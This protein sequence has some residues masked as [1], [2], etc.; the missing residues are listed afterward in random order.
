MQDTKHSLSVRSILWLVA[1]CGAGLL[2]YW[3]YRLVVENV[4]PT[5]PN[6]NGGDFWTFLNAARIITRGQTLYNPAKILGG[7]G[8]VYSPVIAFILV[9]FA[10]AAILK[11]WL[12]YTAVEIIS[13]VIFASVATL[14][15]A[16]YLRSW[17]QPVFFGFTIFTVILFVPTESE[18]YNGQTDAFALVLLAVASLM[19]QYD[20]N[21]ASGVLIGLSGLIKTWPALTVVAIFRRGHRGRIRTLI[22]CATALLVGP[23]LSFII[24]GPSGVVNFIKVTLDA[25]SQP[26][27][28]Y[29]VWGVPNILFSRS[30][31][32]RPVFVSAP[33]RDLAVLSLA[34][35]VIA[36]LLLGLRWSKNPSLSFWN[37][38]GC[39]ILL[40]PVSHGYYTLYL[41]PIFWIWAARWITEPRLGGLVSAV[42]CLLTLWWLVLFHEH[43][44]SGNA[45]V[46]AFHYSVLFFANLAAVTASIIGDHLLGNSAAPKSSGEALG[47]IDD[48][49]A[50]RR[51]VPRHA[52]QPVRRSIYSGGRE[53]LPRRASRQASDLGR[54]L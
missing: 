14:A 29:S 47:D 52:V 9:P 41:L 37:V 12:M 11:L 49:A 4:T 54:G 35:L 10:G 48:S 26:L 36:L 13:F 50:F 27:I 6:G 23:L 15:A 8:Y 18:L 7:T 3:R 53:Y 34:M 46:S 22:G 39:A 51:P 5:G 21:A 38:A 33:L 25:R 19:S 42:T 32:A 30:G 40:L 45:G 1:I 31:L 16:R 17:Q 43:W 20:R 44:D 2:S 24:G 28:S